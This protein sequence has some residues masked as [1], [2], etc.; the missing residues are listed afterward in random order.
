MTT[1]RWNL[2]ER[3]AFRFAFLYFALFLLTHS[4][5]STIPFLGLLLRKYSE[6]WYPVGVWFGKDVLRL[7]YD[8]VPA[9]GGVNNT[10]YGWALCLCY[11]TLAAAGTL[12]W[13]VLGKRRP[14]YERL[15]A[16]LRLLLRFALASAMIHYGMIKLIPTQMIAPP[17]NGV[18][19]FRVG[20]LAP[21]YLLWWFIGASPA[22]ESFTGL[23]ELLGGVLLLVP[24]T[25]LLGAL[26]CAADML[27]VFM[28]NMC[29][30]VIVKLYSLH[31][32]VMAVFM[33]APDLGRLANLLVFNR[34]VAPAETPPLFAHKRLNRVPHVLL[35]LFGVYVIGVSID[36]ALERY[37]SRHPPEPPL[38]GV[39]SVES[40]AVD[41]KDVPLFTDPNRWRWVSFS[42]PGAV[43]V[44]RMIGSGSNYALDLDREAKRMT[45][46]K[47]QLDAEGKTLQD[48]NGKPRKLGN[49]RAELSFEEPE[50]DVLILDGQLD[51]RRMHARLRKM[52]L[53]RKSFRWISDR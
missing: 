33:I 49:W 16:W 10:A 31:L 22:Y 50:P 27:T 23:A 25:T 7:S 46:E 21:N 20:D 39:W 34:R 43:G 37:R 4:T 9:E 8:V 14:D 48:A 13:S 41:G 36:H 18:L 19:L 35:L 51:G 40:F 47:Y 29:Y 32:L 17:P 28:L 42:K 45:L 5:L 3:I 1:L 44:E 15:H 52:A 12:I 38:Y 24:R 11:L 6:L 30:D 2:A 26:V 53:L